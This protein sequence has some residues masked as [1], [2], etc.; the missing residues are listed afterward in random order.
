MTAPYVGFTDWM[1]WAAQSHPMR[2]SGRCPTLLAFPLPFATSYSHSLWKLLDQIPYLLTNIH[3]VTLFRG[4]PQNSRCCQRPVCTIPWRDRN[5]TDLRRSFPTAR[6]ASG[7]GSL[8]LHLP[9]LLLAHAHGFKCRHARDGRAHQED[10][11]FLHVCVWA[12]ARACV[13]IPRR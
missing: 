5:Q 12:H 8:R 6:E 2:L 10:T 7:Q 3:S 1:T 11:V 4:Q 9:A 13:S